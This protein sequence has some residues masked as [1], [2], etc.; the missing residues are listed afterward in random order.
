[1]KNEVMN[2]LELWPFVQ[3]SEE[4]GGGRGWEVC[5]SSIGK[6]PEVIKERQRML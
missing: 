5:E 3:K 1:M 6:I 4:G 2:Q